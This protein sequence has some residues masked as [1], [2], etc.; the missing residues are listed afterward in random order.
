MSQ[1][2]CGATSDH[3]HFTSAFEEGD[4]EDWLAFHKITAQFGEATVHF[5]D[6]HVLLPSIGLII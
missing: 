1:I 3:P 4:S 5:K 2:G 6:F